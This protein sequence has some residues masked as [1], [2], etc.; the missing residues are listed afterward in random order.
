MSKPSGLDAYF[1]RIG[2][3]GDAA[4]TLATLRDI[5]RLHPERIPFENLDP[6]LGL[7]VSLDTA[8]LCDKLVT[9]R[10]GG[11]CYEHNLLLKHALE[12][13]GFRVGGLAARVRW[14]VPEGQ[15]LPLT[16]MLLR[17]EIDGRTWIADV[18]FGGQVL[19]APLLLEPGLL[20]E[21]PHEDY[22][23]MQDGDGYLL[24]WRLLDDWQT[25]YRFDLREQLLPDYEMSNWYVSTHPASRFTTSLAVA[26]TE[27]GRRYTLRNDSFA[28][29]DARGNTERRTLASLVEMKDLL[30]DMFRIPLPGHPDLDARLAGFL[31]S[32]Q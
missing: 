15:T 23:L 32:A 19:T 3:S 14:G 30:R 24:Q 22:R 16:H 12:T 20:Q 27:P 4:P 1:E 29:H 9:R 8:A 31:F 21:T 18:G 6:L 5:H 25:L 11:Y 26:R 10:R 28:I 17:V 13:I 2:Y 7:R